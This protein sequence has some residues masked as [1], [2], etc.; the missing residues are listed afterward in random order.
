MDRAANVRLGNIRA[1]H[2]NTLKE[3]PMKTYLKHMTKAVL[4]A[5][6]MILGLGV[7][8]AQAAGNPD[9]MTIS[10]TPSV[11]YAVTITSVNPNGYQFGQ[12]ALAA[13]TISTW[14]IEIGR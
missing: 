10:V 8:K 13:T 4:A 1:H 6:L 9:T 11:T 3:G 12:I 5:G 2:E 7:M 14:A